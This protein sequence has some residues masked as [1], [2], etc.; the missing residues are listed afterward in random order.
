MIYEPFAILILLFTSILYTSLPVY[1]KTN[2]TEQ[3]FAHFNSMMYLYTDVN[4]R[5]PSSV[6]FDILAIKTAKVVCSNIRRKKSKDG[7]RM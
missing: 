3:T 6:S 1:L 2:L 5:L 4:F 7:M